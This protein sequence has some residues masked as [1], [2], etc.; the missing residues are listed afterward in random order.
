[1]RR[2]T[3][4]T[5]LYLAV[6][7][8]LTAIAFQPPDTT[9]NLEKVLLTNAAVSYL[10]AI[11]STF[12]FWQQA[13][14][15]QALQSRREHA[16]WRQKL[17]VILPWLII[18]VAFFSVIVLALTDHQKTDAIAQAVSELTLILICVEQLF[19]RFRIQS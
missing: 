15:R 14:R 6:G 10:V 1:M 16:D 4:F 13:L 11:L 17:A 2:F 7:V 3:V 12:E 9:P 19:A 5:L 8:C 18:A